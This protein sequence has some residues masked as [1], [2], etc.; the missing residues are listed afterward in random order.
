MQMRNGIVNLLVIIGR[1]Y[2]PGGNW[3][4]FRKVLVATRRS[5]SLDIGLISDCNANIELRYGY[6]QLIRQP[7]LI[8]RRN[9]RL[10]G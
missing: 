4:R 2:V 7:T 9:R 3:I 6:A 5:G 10:N 1:L 8:V